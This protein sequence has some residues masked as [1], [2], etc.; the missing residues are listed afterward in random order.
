[1]ADIT[2]VF[3]VKG[4]DH[5]ALAAVHTLLATHKLSSYIDY[6][7]NGIV[8]R[9]HKESME[10]APMPEVSPRKKP[11]PKPKTQRTD[12]PVEEAAAAEGGTEY[13]DAWTPNKSGYKKGNRSRYGWTQADQAKWR[14]EWEAARDAYLASPV[15]E[16]LNGKA[17]QHRTINQLLALTGTREAETEGLSSAPVPSSSKKSSTKSTSKKPAKTAM[18]KITLKRPAVARRAPRGSKS[19]SQ[20]LLQ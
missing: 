13:R 10:G 15:G 18:K 3:T 19:K 16:L 5:Q 1:M 12:A 9:S 8:S 7:G 6:S 14:V 20:P 17:L 11:G 4:N 2:F